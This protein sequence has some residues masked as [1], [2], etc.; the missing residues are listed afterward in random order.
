MPRFF[1]H[2]RHARKSL[3][4]CDGMVLAD[5]AAARQEAVLAVQDFFQPAT[6]RVPPD[7]EDWSVD[8]RDERGRCVFSA[9]FADAAELE[10]VAPPARV[11]AHA[12][13]N[14]VYLDIVRAK[15]EF[16]ALENQVR[17]L[18]RHTSVLVDRNRY[19]AN[20]LYHLLQAALEVRLRS[21]ELLERS[22]SQIPARDWWVTVPPPSWKEPPAAVQE[23]I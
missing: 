5:A 17:R 3:L 20:V 22:R 14:V 6:G 4:D 13:P 7:W 15:R 10:Q 11:D 2:L 21:R 12:S 16:S 19:E 18:L 23:R 8:V 9:A 1:F